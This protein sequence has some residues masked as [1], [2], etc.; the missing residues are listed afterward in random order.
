MLSTQPVPPCYTLFT[1]MNIPLY[2]F[3]KG[4]GRGG[5]GDPVRRLEVRQF[6]RG[7]EN[8]NMI[9]SIISL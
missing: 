6:T 1:Y 3:T 9:D 2:L 4:R 5:G 8:T 7:I